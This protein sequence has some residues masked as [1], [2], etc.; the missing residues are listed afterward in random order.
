MTSGNFTM[1]PIDADV[2]ARWTG[3]TALRYGMRVFVPAALLLTLCQMATPTWA[4]GPYDAFTVPP[5]RI[6]DTRLVGGAIPAGGSR[7]FFAAGSFSSQGGQ[8]TCGIPLGLAKGVFFNIVAVGP[9]G[10]GHVTL[11]PYPL[12]LPLASTLNVST[13]QTIANGV[14]VAICDTLTADCTSAD[15]TVTMGPASA[16]IVIDVTGYLQ[17][18]P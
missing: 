8:T 15:F 2:R 18:T 10:P 1:T 13:G 17:P 14:L 7:N 16:D 5:C 9:S 11:Y 12:P 6:V 3:M 4:G